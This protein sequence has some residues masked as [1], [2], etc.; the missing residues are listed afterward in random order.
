MASPMSPYAEPLLGATGVGGEVRKLA[1]RS[2]AAHE[3]D[4]VGIGLG[5]EA[6]VRIGITTEEGASALSDH[7]SG[8]ATPPLRR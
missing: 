3:S 7:Q 8:P 2:A 6:K 5:N 1:F 4:L